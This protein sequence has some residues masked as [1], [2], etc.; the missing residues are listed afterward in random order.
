MADVCVYE[1]VVLLRSN[2]LSFLQTGGNHV[3]CECLVPAYE[4]AEAQAMEKNRQNVET[5]LQ[6][7]DMYAGNQC[8]C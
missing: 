4:W 8:S 2:L 3:D 5:L 6:R 7:F 1:N